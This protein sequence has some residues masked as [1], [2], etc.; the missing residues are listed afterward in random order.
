MLT[1]YTIA[2]LCVSIS[3]QAAHA[4]PC[5]FPADAVAHRSGGRQLLSDARLHD[6]QWL[7]V[8]CRGIWG[9]HRLLPVQ[10]AEGS[11]GRHH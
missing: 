9:W 2:N 1:A 8:H 6:L 11:C 10:L 7:P 4:K 3:F 5:P